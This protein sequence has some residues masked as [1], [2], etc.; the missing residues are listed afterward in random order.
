MKLY[1][2]IG[3]RAGSPAAMAL[4]ER[5]AAWHDA[6]VAHERQLRAGR[7]AL[8]CHDDCPHEEARVLWPEAVATFA[9]Q[10]DD[11]SFLKSRASSS[12]DRGRTSRE[13][14][15]NRAED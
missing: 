14:G 1:T 3:L 8:D 4:S 10:A 13:E 11:L 12:V 2:M 7:A 15:G 9:E 5:L 6:M